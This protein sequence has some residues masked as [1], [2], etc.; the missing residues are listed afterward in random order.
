ML[1]VNLEE[2]GLLCQK[3][4][5]RSQ[6]AAEALLARGAARVLVTD[7]ARDATEGTASGLVTQTPPQVLV[8]RVT[9]AGD[10]FMAAHIAA[11][12]RGLSRE[13]ALANALETAATYVS[14]ETPF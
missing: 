12:A 13:A 2:A 5:S 8:A 11:E 9:G 1:Y 7:G 14:G 6:E 3:H 10:T 4:F